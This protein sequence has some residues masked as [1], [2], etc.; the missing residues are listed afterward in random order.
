MISFD[1][2]D[3][4]IDSF[5]S[6]KVHSNSSSLSGQQPKKKRPSTSYS[7]AW[8]S[9]LTFLC[10]KKITLG[11][12][13][14][15]VAL[16]AISDGVLTRT[17]PYARLWRLPLLVDTQTHERFTRPAHSEL[18]AQIAIPMPNAQLSRFDPP[19]FII[20]QKCEK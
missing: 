17:C 5:G 7:N 19:T 6:T 4:L 15:G 1:P 3:P 11:I 9:A 13:L 20:G 2:F 18:A 8:P 12:V 14:M 10:S 16:D